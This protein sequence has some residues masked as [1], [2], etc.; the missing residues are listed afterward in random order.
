MT[1]SIPAHGASVH[2]DRPVRLGDLGGRP[3]VVKTFLSADGGR[4][5]DDHVRLWASPFGA[6]RRPP[7]I[8]EPIAW[9]PGRRELVMEALDGVPI[10][11]RGEPGLAPALTGA[12]ARLLADLHA[13]GAV[14]RR[15]RDGRRLAA[16]LRR[17]ADDM[18]GTAHAGEAARLAADL[19]GRLTAP[20][21]DGGDLVPGHGD[22]SPRNVL[23]TP[24]GVRLIDLDRMQM[25]S[26]ARDVT[27][28]GA[29]MWA[30]LVLAGGR[31]SWGPGERFED[32]YLAHRPRAR[33][34]IAASRGPHRAAALLRIAHGW[35]A[36]RDRPETTRII[37]REARVQAGR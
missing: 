32:A 26:P 7:G 9:D 6:G 27:Y 23:L 31:P 15:R 22:F 17:K 37:L 14:V 11:A 18:S 1:T 25:C 2:A 28:W 13:S 3:V 4:V 8:P 24:A 12:C 33:P 35:S 20:D 34:V 21:A 10:G 19:E 5:H 29:W 16:A 30:T 36:L